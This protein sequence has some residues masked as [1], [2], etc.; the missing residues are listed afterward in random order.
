MF[1]TYHQVSGPYVDARQTQGLAA[2]RTAA[3]T[4]LLEMLHQFSMGAPAA[5]AL[6]R[7][8]AV[9]HMPMHAVGTQCSSGLRRR[10]AGAICEKRAFRASHSRVASAHARW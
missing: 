1:L 3:S 10:M 9:V 8:A 5:D 2:T 4:T 7:A 6:R